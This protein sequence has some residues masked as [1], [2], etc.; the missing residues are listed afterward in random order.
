MFGKAERWFRNW[1]PYNFGIQW[2][3]FRREV[4]KR[5]QNTEITEVVERMAQLRQTTTVIL[6]Q[7][8]FEEAKLKLER[9]HPELTPE[10]YVKCF[11]AGLKP[12]VRAVVRAQEPTDFICCY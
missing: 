1:I 9:A 3:E 6:Y 11:V 12:E 8:Q 7:E 10:Y 2:N 4:Q 5:C